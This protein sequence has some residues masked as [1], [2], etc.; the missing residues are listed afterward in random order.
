M[1]RLMEVRL[2]GRSPIEKLCNTYLE[3]ALYDLE[4]GT[5]CSSSLAGL[6]WHWRPVTDVS[7]VMKPIIEL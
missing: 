7:Q 1:P 2:A 5:V 3:Q 6:L 4:T